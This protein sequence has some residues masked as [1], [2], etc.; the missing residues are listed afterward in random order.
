M[1]LKLNKLTFNKKALIPIQE[2]LKKTLL[3]DTKLTEYIP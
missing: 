1:S 3:P 2:I